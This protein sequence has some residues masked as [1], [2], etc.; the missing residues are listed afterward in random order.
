MIP[1]KNIPYDK[2]F[3]LE[4]ENETNFILEWKNLNKVPWELI[5]LLGC[6]FTLVFLKIN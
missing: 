1:S 4:N 6:G 3:H 2:K 5:F